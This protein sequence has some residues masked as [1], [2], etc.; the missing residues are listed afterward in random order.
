MRL[1]FPTTR[2][3]ETCSW[4][5]PFGSPPAISWLAWSTP[6]GDSLG[7][8]TTNCARHFVR[9]VG[10][11]GWVE[12]PSLLRFQRRGYC[13]WWEPQHVAADRTIQGTRVDTRLSLP[14]IQRASQRTFPLPARPG[15]HLD[16]S[17][18]PSTW[19]P[20]AAASAEVAADNVWLNHV[21]NLAAQAGL[22]HVNGRVPH[23]VHEA[24]SPGTVD[25]RLSRIRVLAATLLTLV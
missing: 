12:Q 11:R 7:T 17:E 3:V 18:G 4:R 10:Y 23:D 14:H 20:S 24:S 16:F 13:S 21:D 5:S 6:P 15:L 22:G 9:R 19:N 25:L 2:R 8:T 1:R